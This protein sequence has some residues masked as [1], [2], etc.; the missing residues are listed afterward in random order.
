VPPLSSTQEL[1]APARARHRVP[2]KSRGRLARRAAVAGV[3]LCIVGGAAAAVVLELDAGGARESPPAARR[4][5]SAPAV[6][7]ASLADPA[8][9]TAFLAGAASD[10]AA[11]TSY[12]YR[13]LDDALN[14]GLAVTTGSYRSAFRA[15][16]TGQLADTARRTHAVHTFQTLALGIGEMSTHTAQ[17]LV[18]GE[19]TVTDRNTGPSGVST[20]VTLR[21]TMVRTGD[22]YLISDLVEGANAGLPPGGPDLPVAA[23]AGRVEVINLLSYQ[24]DDFDA[25]LQ[26]ALSGATGAL[27]TE[28]QA[29]APDTRT[30]MVR[31]QYDLSATVTA[32]AVER[33]NRD[34]LTM[35]V[36][37]AASR[38]VDGRA[39]DVTDMRY[40]VTVVRAG[41]GW[42]ASQVATVGGGG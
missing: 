23:E 27:R 42:A 34:T 19:Q 29:N 12:D 8:A 35:L 24:R 32:V 39:P 4:T 22:R 21:A 41:A 3:A 25:D 15:A 31:G 38:L 30:A 6:P 40:E 10:V 26:R 17:V 20:P 37:A 18:F 2:A 36:A 1:R 7:G 11:V 14:A 28:I 13:A 5:S 16:L 33:A 9:A